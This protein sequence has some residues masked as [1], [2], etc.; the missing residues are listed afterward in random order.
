LTD[1]NCINLRLPTH[2]GLYAWEFEK[3]GRELRVRVEGQLVLNG[4]TQM[5]NAALA[6]LGLA[7]VPEDLAQP[8]LSERRL[9]RALEDW[10]PPYSSTIQ[11]DASP[12][13]RL[14]F[15]SMRCAAGPDALQDS[16]SGLLE[17]STGEGLSQYGF[18]SE[19]L[20]TGP[21]CLSVPWPPLDSIMTESSSA[22][23]GPKSGFG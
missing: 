9:Q 3:G 18:V 21:R 4:T 5:L 2:G 16:H 23:V 1:H 19:R 22:G 14:G 12:R 8:H 17:P 20:S 10:C 11:A 6:G 13:R 15:W 7:Y